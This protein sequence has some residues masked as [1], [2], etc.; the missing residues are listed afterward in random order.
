MD[1]ESL[2]LLEFTQIKNIISGYT[3]F[4]KS[5]KLVLDIN[6]SIEQEVINHRLMLSAEA[7]RLLKVEP[8]F[9]LEGTKDVTQPADSASRGKTLDPQQFLDIQHSLSIC[10]R[11]KIFF[12]RRENDFPLLS[13]L[14]RNMN[15]LGYIQKEVSRTISPGGE[16]CTDASQPL[17]YIRN[18]LKIVRDELLRK[19]DSIVKSNESQKV[20]QEPIITQREGRYVVPVKIEHKREFKGIVHDVS[21]TGATVF[22]EPWSTVDTGNELKQLELEESREIER[23]L[24]LL[25]G[26]IGSQRNEVKQNID[27]LA[28]IDLELAKA[29]F[30]VNTGSLEPCINDFKKS[31]SLKLVKARHP[32]LGYK[33]VPLDLEIGS[34]ATS[35][36]ITGPNTGGKTVALKTIG[37]LSLMVQSGLPVPAEASSQFPVFDNIFADIG[38]EQSIENTL[39]SFS[40][41]ISNISRILKQAS[42]QSLVLLDE[43]GTSTDPVEGSALA[44]AIVNYLADENI[45]TVVTSHFNELKGLAH[46]NSKMQNASFEFDPETFAPTFRLITGIPGGSNAL[47]T[48]SRLG[49]PPDIID[50]AKN[51]LAS[52]AHNLDQL[53]IEIANE[54]AKAAKF[55]RDA[56]FEKQQAEY[57]RDELERRLEEIKETEEQILDEARD[58]VVKE[59]TGLYNEIKET[60][61][62]LKKSRSKS[63]L[64]HAKAIAEN[65]HKKIRCLNLNTNDTDDGE[66]FHEGDL[67]WLKDMEVEAQVV[68]INPATSQLT[69]ESGSMRFTLDM[70]RVTKVSPGRVAPKRTYS[71]QPFTVQTHHA[72]IEIDLRGKRADDVEWILEEY[73]SKALMSNLESVRI[74]HGYGTGTLRQ[75]VRAYLSDNKL[76][77]SIKPGNLNEGGD[78]VTVVTFK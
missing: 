35:L 13:G 30:A 3:S 78:G 42:N 34:Y 20:L 53:L 58:R 25:S 39:S 11:T 26:K 64:K 16:V 67:V 8:A 19:L 70:K 76:I 5:K 33:A 49:I 50:A 72:P 22:I 73:I 21:N 41:H 61:S 43:L 6:P 14:A 46:S 32:L 68:S 45:T 38:D 37:L 24:S 7:R 56:M 2:R 57:A 65:S 29:K 60:T 9:S 75:I 54:K 69:A 40:W 10:H 27:I 63:Q 44:A 48:A 15:E 31:R 36:I 1:N 52:P 12:E 4:A 66:E 59:V 47:I 23:I 77:N 17:K 28:E 74:I 18:Q 51:R 55:S 62:Q 71:K